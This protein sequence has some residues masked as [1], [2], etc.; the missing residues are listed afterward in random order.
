MPAQPVVIGQ[1]F[2]AM[3]VGNGGPDGGKV[4]IF[5]TVTSGS[6]TNPG[7]FQARSVQTGT[8]EATF[9][10]L[11]ADGTIL[12][13]FPCPPGDTNL[14]NLPGGFTTSLTWATVRAR[15][16]LQGGAATITGR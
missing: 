16:Y 11:N 6:P 10:V 9:V 8:A 4:T 2:E 7:Q 15:I 1:E 12:R 14:V 3:S 5:V 13:T